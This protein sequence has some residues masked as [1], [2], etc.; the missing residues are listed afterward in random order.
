MMTYI[1]DW[2]ENKN[3]GWKVANIHEVV[4]N[5]AVYQDVSIN[6]VDKKNRE[7]SGWDGIM[8]GAQV[9]GNIWRSPSGKF[10]LFAPDPTPAAASPAAA[11]TSPGSTTY[12]P[13]QAGGG[14][15]R[16]VAA[17]QQRKAE[18]IEKAQ[19]R[20][21]TGIMVSA[22]MRD[23][24]MIATALMESQSVGEPWSFENF[25]DMF[26]RVKKWYL[27]KWNETEKSLDIPF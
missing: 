22:A 18:G 7:F 21:E 24:T 9:T 15:P 12:R 26:E 10:T 1:V 2:V 11:P 14:A 13:P 6:R 3:D 4:E 8:P 19:D 23:S 16:G 20:K 17:A 25:T 5:G 27:A